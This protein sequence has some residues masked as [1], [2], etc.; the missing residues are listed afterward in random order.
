M[1]NVFLSRSLSFQNQILLNRNV[2]GIDASMFQNINKL[3]ITFGT[4][5]LMDNEDRIL[6]TQLFQETLEI[7]ERIRYY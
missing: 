4:L 2:T 6:A 1:S 3:H 5:S 7:V